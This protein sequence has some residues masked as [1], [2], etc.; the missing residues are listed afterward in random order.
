LAGVV[1][2][3]LPVN[4]LHGVALVDSDRTTIVATGLWAGR[5]VKRI[6]TTVCGQR[7]LFVRVTQRGGFGRV[8]VTTSTP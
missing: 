7:S 5:A 8:A 4:G 1:T 6:T 3:T 2:V